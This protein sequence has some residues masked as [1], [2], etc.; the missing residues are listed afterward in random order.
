MDQENITTEEKELQEALLLVPEEV[1]EFMWS[2]AF[3]YILDAG[4]KVIPLS[5][6]EKDKTRQTAYDL[7]LQM[8]TMEKAAEKLVAG[9]IDKEKTIKILYFIDTEIL[10]RAKNLIENENDINAQIEELNKVE[11]PSPM[12]AMASI[13]ERLTKPTTVAPITRDY[14]VTRSLEQNTPKVESAPRPPSMDIY[15]EVPDK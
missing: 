11:A 15:R 3:E 14:S 1:Q 12:Q 8:T 6:D 2:D 13:Q 4:E 9:G 7:L 10:T 5:K